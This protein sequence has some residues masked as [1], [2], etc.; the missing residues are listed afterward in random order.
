MIWHAPTDAHPDGRTITLAR[1]IE[2][3]DRSAPETKA[4][5][6]D[7]LGISQH[8]LSELLQELKSEGIVTKAY[9]VDDE[10]VYDRARSVSELWRRAERAGAPGRSELLALL[11]RLDEVTFE[12]Y[13]AAL[14]TFEGDP[15]EGT[16]DALEPLSNERYST[17][18]GELKSLTMTVDWPGNRV[19]ADLASIAKNLEIVGDRA[20]F[21]SDAIEVTEETPTG[22][23]HDRV[24]DVFEAG[25]RIHRHFCAV[26]FECDLARIEELHAEEKR[27]HRDLSELFELA[28]A[29]DP[30]TYGYLVTVTRALERVIH[31]WANAAELA[32]R[33]HA[34]VDPGHVEI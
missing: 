14:A 23:V 13:R 25:E 17:V 9:V 20:C 28:T 22:T 19:A 33:I 5:A 27:V 8:Y 16:A 32:V 4:E 15:P 3:I 26:L 21:V 12:Q 7:R 11:R 6:A 34:G 18:L 30:D 24:R 1:V 31:Y 2:T 10:R 29:Y